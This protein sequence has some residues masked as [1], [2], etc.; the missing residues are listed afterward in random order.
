MIPPLRSASVNTKSNIFFYLEP[1]VGCLK[2]Q[3]VCLNVTGQNQTDG[4]ITLTTD[5]IT[6]VDIQMECLKQCQTY[7][8]ATGCQ[9][10]ISTTEPGCRVHTKE[11]TGGDNSG[12]A[13]CWVFSKC[14]GKYQHFFLPS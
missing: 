13:F 8:G 10:T 6:T 7:K 12:S 9:A 1:T 5:I 3:G 4:A 2:E 11:V 14:Q